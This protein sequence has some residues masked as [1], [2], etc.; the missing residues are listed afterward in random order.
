MFARLM[1]AVCWPSDDGGLVTSVSCVVADNYY[2]VRYVHDDRKFQVSNG[3]LSEHM[4]D[5][6]LEGNNSV[7]VGTARA[8][9][10]ACLSRE[11]RRRGIDRSPKAEAIFFLA[12]LLVDAVKNAPSPYADVA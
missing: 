9:A 5:L 12:S 4:D 2:A 6:V 1:S 10:H 3:V 8:A 7:I 11:L